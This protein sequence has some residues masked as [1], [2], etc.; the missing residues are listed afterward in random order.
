[1]R[2]DELER[3]ITLMTWSRGDLEAALDGLPDA[4]LDW[5]PPTSSIAST[6]TWAPEVRTIREIMTHVLQLEIYY[7]DALRDGAAK[8]IFEAPGDPASERQRTFE[9]LRSLDDGARSRVYLPVRPSRTT[10]EEWT[11]RKLVRRIISHE[12]VHAAEV[13]QRLTW[14]LL[15][16]PRVR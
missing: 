8:G 7:R 2:S 1:M 4:L 12:R 9:Q 13:R 5:A 15:G 6:D 14:L 3:L 10:P 16:V 11:V